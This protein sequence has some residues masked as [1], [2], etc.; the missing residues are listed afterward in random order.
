MA[1]RDIGSESL[2]SPSVGSPSVGSPS[3]SSATQLLEKLG[4]AGRT[5]HVFTGLVRRVKGSEELIEFTQA[6]DGSNWKE[7]QVSLVEDIQLLQ[8][9]RFDNH[10]YPLVRLFMKEPKMPEGQAFAALARPYVALAEDWSVT[11]ETNGHRDSTEE[12]SPSPLAIE[13]FAPR[14]RPWPV[15]GM[16]G[17][18]HRPPWPGGAGYAP[19]A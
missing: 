1:K 15:P 19:P 13:D 14:R 18:W 17:G 9:V 4:P 8:L 16:G 10:T 3:V 5:T 7:I 6:R 2:G 12:F 11:Q